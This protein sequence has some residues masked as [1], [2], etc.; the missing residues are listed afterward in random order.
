MSVC[1]CGV[2]CTCCAQLRNCRLESRERERERVHNAWSGGPWYPMEYIILSTKNEYSGRQ[3]ERKRT[4]KGWG[5]GR[6]GS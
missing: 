3:K 4:D 5:S 2:T 1:V 6:W